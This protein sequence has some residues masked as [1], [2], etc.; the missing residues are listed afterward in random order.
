M[1]EKAKEKLGDEN[2]LLMAELLELENFDEEKEIKANRYEPR[3]RKKG[4][5]CVI[6]R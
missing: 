5:H 4:C 3:S 2:A 6:R 1:I